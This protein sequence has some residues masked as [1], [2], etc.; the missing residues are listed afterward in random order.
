MLHSGPRRFAGTGPGPREGAGPE[1]GTGTGAG[2]GCRTGHA[3]PSS[4]R[5]ASTITATIRNRRHS[6]RG[7]PLQH[8]RHVPDPGG[9]AGQLLLLFDGANIS[10]RIDRNTAAAASARA[11]ATTLLVAATAR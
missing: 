7:C 11:A 8:G 10:A 4:A 9:F 5:A 2:A 1:T 3:A 6:R